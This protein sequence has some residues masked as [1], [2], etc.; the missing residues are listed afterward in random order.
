MTTKT[1]QYTINSECG[2]EEIYAESI[3]AAKEQYSRMH[4]F[5]FNSDVVGSWYYVADEHGLLVDGNTDNM[6]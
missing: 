1:Q 2:V 6:P 4:N 5:D 3:E